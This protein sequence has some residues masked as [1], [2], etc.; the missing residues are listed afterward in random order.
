M[1]FTYIKGK[2]TSVRTFLGGGMGQRLAWLRQAGEYRQCHEG[3][4][5]GALRRGRGRKP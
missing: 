2:R 3:A 1:E 5:A 4:G